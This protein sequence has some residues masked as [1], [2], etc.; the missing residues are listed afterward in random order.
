MRRSFALAC[1]TLLVAVA[2]VACRETEQDRVLWY[3]KGTYLG[4]A[5]SS[6]SETTREDLRQRTQFQ[7]ADRS[8]ASP[9]GGAKA[10]GPD[11]RPPGSLGAPLSEEARDAMRSRAQQQGLK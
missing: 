3:E 11:V 2:L 6:L 8:V 1:G 5:D 9:G 7:S 10:P 4:Q